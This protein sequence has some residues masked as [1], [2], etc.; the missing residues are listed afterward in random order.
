MSCACFEFWN[1]LTKVASF[2]FCLGNRDGSQTKLHIFYRLGLKIM[3]YVGRLPLP[4][5]SS[6]EA[7]N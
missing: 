3:R 2:W 6:G 5:L 4:F 1:A 7:E